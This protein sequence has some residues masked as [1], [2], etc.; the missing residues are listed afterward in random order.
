MEEWPE[1]FKFARAEDF[2][3]NR[4]SDV[5][6]QEPQADFEQA[7]QV[8]HV[9]EEMGV[10]SPHKKRR[11]DVQQ[12][13][14]VGH[15]AGAQLPQDGGLADVMEAEQEAEAQTRV[16]IHRCHNVANAFYVGPLGKTVW[17]KDELRDLFLIV[18]GYPAFMYR[19]ANVSLWV[20]MAVLMGHM[21]EENKLKNTM[22]QPHII[23]KGA[24]LEL[25]KQASTIDHRS[26]VIVI[27][28]ADIPPYITQHKGKLWECQCCGSAATNQD[29]FRKKKQCKKQ[30]LFH[31]LIPKTWGRPLDK[32]TPYGC[33]FGHSGP[34]QRV[35]AA[36]LVPPPQH[37]VLGQPSHSGVLHVASPTH[38]SPR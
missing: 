9:G 16:K 21:R 36:P 14:L 1:E 34:E 22:R 25:T 23:F 2:E 5:H 8:S 19:V 20:P 27:D 15:D 11:L 32:K 30:F 17:S 4:E 31:G 10:G 29:H 18:P 7:S 6:F 28:G 26:L 38:R 3:H 24:E 33:P 37:E 12:P 13:D 35:A